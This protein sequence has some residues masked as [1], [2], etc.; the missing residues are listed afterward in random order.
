MGSLVEQPVGYER[1]VDAVEAGA[2]PVGHAGEAGTDVAPA[3]QDAAAVEVTGVV[4]DRLDAQH[5]LAFGV[6]LQRQAPE[7]DLEVG[8]VIRRCPDHG[9]QSRRPAC[10]VAVGPGLGAEH[11]ADLP[12][13]EAGPGAV[14]DRVEGPLHAGAVA[15]QQV[16]GV[17]DLEDRVVVDE[18][19]RRLVRCVQPEAQ[20]GRVDPPVAHLAQPPCCPRLGHGVCDLREACRFRNDSKA[21]ALL[22]ELDAGRGGGGDDVLVAVEDHLGPEGRVARHL[23]G[24]VP[25]GRVHDVE[26]LTGLRPSPTRRCGV[27]H[28]I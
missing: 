24:H 19:A 23:D 5:V 7:V 6:G 3:V 26:R 12:H 2:E 10:S 11:G 17:L 28:G 25:P 22:G 27:G 21:V 16:A 20:A 1:H 18:A 15:E 8:E 14:H 13:V 9:F 4:G